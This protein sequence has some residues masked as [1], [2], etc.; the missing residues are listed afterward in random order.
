LNNS[1]GISDK[2]IEVGYKP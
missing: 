1:L 2:N